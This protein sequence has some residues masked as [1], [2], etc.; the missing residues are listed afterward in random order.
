MNTLY[1]EE[2]AFLLLLHT[3]VLGNWLSN[4]SMVDTRNIKRYYHAYRLLRKSN[5]VCGYPPS[6]VYGIVWSLLYA[7]IVPAIFLFYYYDDVRQ[8]DGAYDPRVQCAIWLLFLINLVLNKSWDFAV[9]SKCMKVAAYLSAVLTLLVALT[10]SAIAV[11]FYYLASCDGVSN[12]LYFSAI[13]FTV[14]A[15]WGAYATYLGFSKASNI[16]YAKSLLLK[17]EKSGDRMLTNNK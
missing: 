17:A 12:N 6:W 10:A 4:V 3:A 9:S 15:S 7:L 5:R 11:L 1:R 8:V 2:W 13:V 16:E 14:Y